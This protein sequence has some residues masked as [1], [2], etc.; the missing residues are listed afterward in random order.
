MTKC[1]NELGLSLPIKKVSS[2]VY[3]VGERKVNVTLSGSGLLVTLSSGTQLD[4]REWLAKHF[5]IKR[6]TNS[7]QRPKVASSSNLP[8]PK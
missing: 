1:L 6:H 8:L 5:M 7:A 2:A 3:H 4:F